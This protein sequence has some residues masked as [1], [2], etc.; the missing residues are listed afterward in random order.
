MGSNVHSLPDLFFLAAVVCYGA[1]RDPRDYMILKRIVFNGPGHSFL[2]DVPPYVGFATSL[3]R[4]FL[5]AG[6]VIM[7]VSGFAGAGDSNHGALALPAEQFTRQQI[8]TTLTMASLWIL[9]RF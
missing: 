9:F 7:Q 3:F 1:V 2:Y 6:V 4:P 5:L 8:V